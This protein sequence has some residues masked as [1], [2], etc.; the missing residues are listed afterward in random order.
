MT[1]RD[2]IFC[3]EVQGH[4]SMSQTFYAKMF[5]INIILY[6]K[7]MDICIT[8][9][10]YLKAHSKNICMQFQTNRQEFKLEKSNTIP[11]VHRSY[12]N[13]NLKELNQRCPEERMDQFQSLA[14]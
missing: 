2:D 9:T 5:S 8:I 7:Y 1:R 11:F 13:R 14:I 10:N 3:N 4:R 12:Q 6:M